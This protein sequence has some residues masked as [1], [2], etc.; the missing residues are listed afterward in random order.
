MSFFSRPFTPNGTPASARQKIDEEIARLGARIVTLK[1]TRNTFSPISRLH[2]ELV[3]AIFVFAS[4][5]LVCRSWREL[6]HQT[7]ALWSYIDFLNPTW[8]EFALSR[9]R[10]RQLD[11]ELRLRPSESRFRARDDNDHLE[12]ISLCRENFYRIRTLCLEGNAAQDALELDTSWSSLWAPPSLAPHLVELILRSV[13]LPVDFSQASF[14]SLK[15]LDLRAGLTSLTIWSPVSKI[16]AEGL[17]HKL[18]II[19][20]DVEMLTKTHISNA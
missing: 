9:T 10:R 16:S 19:G 2:P 4:G 13:R 5:L 6:A 3:Q 12:V 20:P 18:Q 7:S 15:K 11:F 1:T 8:V 17:V 14:P